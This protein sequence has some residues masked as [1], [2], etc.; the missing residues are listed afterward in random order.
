MQTSSLDQTADQTCRRL[1]EIRAAI[2]AR[3][4]QAGRP[5]GAV[6]LIAV[7]K[8]FAAER[9][10]PALDA[11]QRI[12]GENRVREAA[13][14][15]PALKQR[16]GDVELHLIGPLQS[17][18]VR[19]ALGLFEVIHTVDRP[20]LAR[21]IARISAELG[22]HP[23]C[24]IQINTGEEPQKA[25]I[26]PYDA[27]NFIALCR[28]EIGLNIKGLM[29]IPPVAEEP[30]LHFALLRKIAERNRLAGLSM[31]MS[32]DFETAIDFGATCVRLGSA[33]FG[34]RATP[35]PASQG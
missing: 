23:R 12:F 1:A 7:S 24:Y 5:A 28:D 19:Q 9:I 34:P 22:V 29:C 26:A 16:Y 18:K 13:A 11:G 6:Q 31:G 33:I 21:A 30:A 35:P 4:N 27:D 17:N 15:W 10:I 20:K 8:T 2:A 25:G 3:A 14:K 32:A